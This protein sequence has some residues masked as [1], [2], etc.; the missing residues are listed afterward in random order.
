MAPHKSAR[1]AWSVALACFALWATSASATW[2]Q[3]VAG[4]GHLL[5][6]GDDNTAVVSDDT[7]VLSP[8]CPPLTIEPQQPVV[9]VP[10]PAA[11]GA[12]SADGAFHL[13]GS[14][15]Q[16]SHAIEQLI[17]GRGFSATLSARGDGCAD[18]SI[19]A[20]SPSIANSSASSDLSVSLGSGQ[21]LSIQIVSQ[22]GATRVNIGTG[23]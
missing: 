19:H 3:A 22:A 16:V 4:A 17:G 6:Q 1:L 14:D 5:E 21:R 12:S 8:P 7:T 15:P 10:E 9:A 13:C 2:G 18:L 23:R 11:S 20:T